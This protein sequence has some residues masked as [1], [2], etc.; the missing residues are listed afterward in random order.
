MAPDPADYLDDDDD[1][2]DSEERRHVC[3]HSDEYGNETDPCQECLL[4]A[5]GVRS[6]GAIEDWESTARLP[7]IS[8]GYGFH[9]NLLG[10]AVRAVEVRCLSKG[11][12]EWSYL[13]G[14]GLKSIR[15]HV[16]RWLRK[17]PQYQDIKFWVAHGWRLQPGALFWDVTSTHKKAWLLIALDSSSA[18]RTD[19]FV[20][21]MRTLRP[22]HSFTIKDAVS[23]I[24]SPA[25]WVRTEGLAIMSAREVGKG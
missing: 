11:K 6:S 13:S 2:G 9:A 5:F 18:N 14:K 25:D 10:S 7:T 12:E 22:R 23:L 8:A 15:P 24:A 17:D 16:L 21:R 19:E 4:W 1:D 20:K 3:G